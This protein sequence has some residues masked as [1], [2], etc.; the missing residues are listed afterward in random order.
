MKKIHLSG[1]VKSYMVVFVLPLIISLAAV[2]GIILSSQVRYNTTVE[3]VSLTMTGGNS[4]V[5]AGSSDDRNYTVSYNPQANVF[6]GQFAMVIFNTT[7]NAIPINATKSF[8]VS[9][10][11]TIVRG[12]CSVGSN[13]VGETS[14]EWTST[15][16]LIPTG[17][18]FIVSVQYNSDILE[19]TTYRTQS[20]VLGR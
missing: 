8:V 4:I 19:G 2:A 13:S 7:S 6:F 17:T 12:F 18:L 11:G 15:L 20:R 5:L 1:R 10:N 14:C 16:Q 3:H 9:V